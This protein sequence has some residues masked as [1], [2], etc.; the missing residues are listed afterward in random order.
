M[1]LVVTLM[2]RAYYAQSPSFPNV[3][4]FY[5]VDPNWLKKDEGSCLR[6]D[7]VVSDLPYLSVLASTS[8][9]C[10]PQFPYVQTE[11]GWSRNSKS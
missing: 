2:R 1:S 4:M 3:K 7:N 11:R 6:T 5:S 9:L 10:G 8:N